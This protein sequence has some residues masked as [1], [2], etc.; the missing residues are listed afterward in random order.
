ML[1]IVPGFH[2][3]VAYD[4][5]VLSSNHLHKT[6]G[7]CMHKIIV[8]FTFLL[9]ING[10]PDKVLCSMYTK[11]IHDG[12]LVFYRCLRDKNSKKAQ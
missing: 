6:Q 1:L 4:T 11:S 3:M 7:C 2:I 5:K 10:L 9:L 8:S 12:C